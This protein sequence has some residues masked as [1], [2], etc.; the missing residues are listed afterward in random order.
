M[1]D[2]ILDGDMMPLAARG[3]EQETC[4]FIYMTKSVAAL[5]RS[6]APAL[7]FLGECAVTCWERTAGCAESPNSRNDKPDRGHNLI[8]YYKED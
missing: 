1:N 4:V 6:A 3:V 2:L 7:S 5:R 8:L